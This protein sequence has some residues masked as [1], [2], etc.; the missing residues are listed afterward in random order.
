MTNAI[1]T[2]NQVKTTNPPTDQRTKSPV[3]GA[4][5]TSDRSPASAIVELSSEQVL[6]KMKTLPEVDSQRIESIKSAL[7]NGEYNPD[8]EVIA[9]K[10]SEIENLL[11]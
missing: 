7:A 9:R 10:F 3:E 11:P 4:S 1:N 8:P 6:K 5:S 2:N